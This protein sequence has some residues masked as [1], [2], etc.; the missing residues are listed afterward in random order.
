MYNIYSPTWLIVI[1]SLRAQISLCVVGI[2][3]MLVHTWKL[4]A[5]KQ[6]LAALCSLKKPSTSI[7]REKNG[8]NS[9]C[10]I[11]NGSERVLQSVVVVVQLRPQASGNRAIGSIE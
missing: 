9:M 6:N 4:R 7:Y 2:G 10:A 3:A 8:I 5:I 11:N 1:V